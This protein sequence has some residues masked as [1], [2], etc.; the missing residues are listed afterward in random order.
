MP[1]DSGELLNASTKTE[2]KQFLHFKS[3]DEF[4]IGK[5]VTLMSHCTKIISSEK[6]KTSQKNTPLLHVSK[7]EPVEKY[8][9]TS[10]MAE[11]RQEKRGFS[12]PIIDGRF[13]L[14]TMI[15]QNYSRV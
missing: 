7:S 9:C 15:L 14:H 6:E 13:F 11:K 10:N 12:G 5:T 8:M 3:K 4:E 2:R 1:G